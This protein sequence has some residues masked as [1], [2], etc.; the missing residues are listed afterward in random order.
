MSPRQPRSRSPFDRA[1]QTALLLATLAARAA[2]GDAVLAFKTPAPVAFRIAQPP[3]PATAGVPGPQWL[4]AFPLSGSTNR[5]ELGSRLV[6][7]LADAAHLAALLKMRP[8]ECVRTLGTNLFILRA[9][10]ALTAAH[11]AALLA[12]QPGVM[13]CYP[14]MRRTPDLHGPYAP[15]PNDPFAV[16]YFYTGGGQFVEAQWPL[17]HREADGRALGFDL[18]VF[19]AWPYARGEGVTVA[20]ADSGLDFEHPEL[21]NRLAGA[22]HWNFDR[23]DTNATPFG[24]AQSDPNKSFWTH[25]TSVA[26][27]I[28]AEANN[29]RGM[30]GVAP[31]ARLAAWAI[32]TTNLLL[33]DDEQL[34]DMYP[35]ASNVVAVQ[36]H[37]W[38]TG[39]GVA[40]AGPTLLEQVGIN[41]AVTL[42]RNGRGV[43]MVRAGGNDR[44]SMARADDDG[45]VNDP[46]VIGVAAVSRGGRATDYSEPGACL[47][48]AAPGGAG[49]YQGLLTLDLAGPF[50][51][52]NSGVFYLN[53]FA[54]YR[55]GAFLGFAGTSAAAPLV[56]GIAALLLSAN[57]ELTY[58]DVQQILL[59]SARQT[60]P[61]DPDLTTNGAGLVVSHNTGFGVPDAGHAVWLARQ[62]SNRPPLATF[63]LARND[64]VA[65]PDGGLRLEIVGPGAPPELASVYAL[66]VNAG[67]HP[68]TP[69]AALPLVDVGV[70]TNVPPLNLT[71]KAALILRSDA[72]FK[73]VLANVAAA[74]A[75][76]A[77]I[78]NDTNSGGFNLGLLV[79][80]EFVPIP[81][82]LV[83]HSTGEAL[84]AVFQTNPLARARLRLT[85]A[86]VHFDVETA[87]LCEQVGVRLRLEHPTRG[88]LRI[89]LRSPAGTRSVF[90]HLNDDTNAASADWTYWS[91][92]HFYESSAGRWTL[93]VSDEALGGTGLVR[94]ATLLVRGVQILDADR[95]G[96]DDNW[97]R[98]AFGHP[99][100]GP[101][102]D[103]DGDGFSNAREQVMRTDPSRDERVFRVDLSTWT[104]FGARRVRLS[105]PSVPGIVYNVAATTNLHQPM[106]TLTNV[107]G[108]IW[109]TDF[110][111]SSPDLPQN[112]FRVMALPSP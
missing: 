76:F 30:A 104:L 77:V 75:A 69:T 35:F 81:G 79:G 19:A 67:A 111:G 9:P 66:P 105:W 100:F 53:D 45:Y 41:T 46:N 18:N 108:R 28:A 49:G 43:V 52:V 13:A 26:G 112:F 109:D 44:G 27:L 16:P 14:V 78:R 36:N 71:N 24:G 86:E 38:G 25:G 92:H 89:T 88:D 93:N 29:A 83:G 1:L 90:A 47:L 6:V 73:D 8:L 55:T 2:T 34:M 59:L 106:V 101:K 61:A 21:T 12:E 107:P 22:P 60:D 17:E 80:S 3:A 56:S 96:L 62:W 82:V 7:Q 32:F 11:Q 68:D 37:S 99:G 54:D 23:G 72:P 10:D 31:Q 85:S 64:A 48:V 97:E 63:S 57:P 40:Q 95:D 102:D 15:R 33:V 50:R 98:A 4:T 91:T 103:P 42:G 39:A 65:I 87:L 70:A 110:Y 51:G 5:V 58:R 74:G 94:S 84:Q 20:V